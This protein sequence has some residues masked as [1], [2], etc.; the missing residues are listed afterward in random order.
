[1]PGYEVMIVDETGHSVADGEPGEL[2]VRGPSAA[3]G[4]WNQ[5]DKSRR[6]FRGEWTHTGD[7]YTRDADGYY[8]YNGRSDDML[9]V[10]GVWVSPFEVEEA[11]IGHEAV[12]EAAVVGQPDE[13]RLIK[14]KAFVVLQQAARGDDPAALTEALQEHVKARIGVWK[15][16]RWIEFRD[17]LPKTA[18]GKIQRY[19]LRDA[20]RA[21]P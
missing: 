7:T 8:R 18:T 11:L 13:D 21:T 19:Q 4:Y 1:V 14:P 9:K 15:Y 20:G 17:A 12:L 6:T 5:R 2:I 10:G 16:P 3:E